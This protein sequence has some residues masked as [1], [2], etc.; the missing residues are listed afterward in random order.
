MQRRHFL[1]LL[2]APCLGREASAAEPG[3]TPLFDGQ[4][5]RGW[6][7]EDGP[8]SAFYIDGGDVAIHRGGND[9]AWLRSEKEYENFDL[10]GEFFL[11]G[12]SDSG[13]L[14]HAPLHGKPMYTGMRINVFHQKDDP[15]NPQS[16][17]AIFPV[18]A[19]RLVNVRNQGE[20]NDFRILSDWP[21]LQVWIN[22][23]MV[24]DLDVSAHP[25]LKYRLRRGYLGLV[26]LSYPV[27]FR[28]F[29]IRELPAKERWE[30]L[31]LTPADAGKWFISEGKPQLDLLGEVIYV[32]GAGHWATKEKFRDFELQLYIRGC[33]QHNGGVLFR[34]EGHGTKGFRY[35][36]QLHNVEGAHYPTGSLYGIHRARYPRIEDEKWFH[37]HL[38]VQG[39]DCLVRINGETVCEYHKLEKLD[40]G[41]IELQGHRQGYWLEF[42]RVLVKRLG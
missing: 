22:G 26:S 40:E 21:K 24:Q 34:S 30:P 31:Y 12:W 1:P 39:P 4:T 7:V 18:V 32:D 27:R 10:R 36:I 29:R 17:G 20:W 42:K 41:Y 19:P 25:E 23:A 16:A 37:F 3:F 9:P 11:K 14:I 8:P 35:E 38:R 15:P 28:N 5:L 6:T 33:R 2:A 13:I